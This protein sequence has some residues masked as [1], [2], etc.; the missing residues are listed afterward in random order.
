MYKMME[1]NTSF[2]T[3]QKAELRRN[4]EE[5]VWKDGRA[6]CAIFQEYEV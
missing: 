3:Y 4:L 5:K 1:K 6:K 2:C